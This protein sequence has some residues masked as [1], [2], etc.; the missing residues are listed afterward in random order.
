MGGLVLDGE[1]VNV[2]DRGDYVELRIVMKRS[3]WEDIKG[4][5]AE[6]GLRIEEF[7]FD[8]L[9]NVASA[10]RNYELWTKSR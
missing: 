2:I 6:D 10:G 3:L 7:I 5:I 4:W 8:I 1:K 9:V